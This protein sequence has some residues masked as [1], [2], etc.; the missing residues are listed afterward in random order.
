MARSV[1]VVEEVPEVEEAEEDIRSTIPTSTE[2]PT[3][4][5]QPSP[6]DQT[7]RY[8][9]SVRLSVVPVSLAL[10]SLTT[11]HVSPLSVT[12]PPVSLSPCVFSV[13]FCLYPSRMSYLC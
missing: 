3:R 10:I 8:A 11:L 4:Q 12:C 6:P 5:C 2:H 7:R 1:E 9:R 13:C